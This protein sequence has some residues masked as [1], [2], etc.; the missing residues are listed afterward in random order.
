MEREANGNSAVPR[1]HKLQ[2][3]HKQVQ[4]VGICVQK[5]DWIILEVEQKLNGKKK[6]LWKFCKEINS[7]NEAACLGRAEDAV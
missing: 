6:V 2:A 4:Q 1:D 5:S 3:A 7:P